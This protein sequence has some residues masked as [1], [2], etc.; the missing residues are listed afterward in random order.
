M[1]HLLKPS[2]VL[3]LTLALGACWSSCF[4]RGTRVLTPRGPRPIEDLAIGDEV[5]SFD[6]VARRLVVRRV[7]RTLRALAAETFRIDA[8]EHTVLGVTSEHP[9]FD[10]VA[11]EYRPVSA[12]TL[13]AQLLVTVGNGDVA[14]RPLDALTRARH[15]AEVEVFNLTIEGEEQ[16]YF[17]EGILV[18]NKSVDPGGSGGSGGSG[19]DST[20]CPAEAPELT[21]AQACPQEGLICSYG[22]EC[23]CG[24]CSPSYVCEC[25]GG[26]WS[27]YF[28]DA[29]FMPQCGSGG[30]GGQGGQ[31]GG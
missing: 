9:F 7:A 29:C 27:C 10:A 16:N 20:E 24:S 15:K 3:G 13:R 23:C 8:G 5:V 26:D 22:E 1:S 17:A 19:G 12:L 28:T 14:A 18:H 25:N 31:G 4:V 6:V 11:G 30:G 21:D 2:L